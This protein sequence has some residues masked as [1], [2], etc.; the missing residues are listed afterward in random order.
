MTLRIIGCEGAEFPAGAATGAVTGTGGWG[1]SS[2]YLLGNRIVRRGRIDRPLVG[3]E[4]SAVN[5]GRG[6]CTEGSAELEASA[7]GAG[8]GGLEGEG[9]GA[10]EFPPN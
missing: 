7:A 9:H 4:S 10:D 5:S 6:S 1:N 2:R 8:L 3:F